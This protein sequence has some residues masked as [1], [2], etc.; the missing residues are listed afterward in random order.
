MGAI[1]NVGFEAI[2]NIVNERERNGKFKSL[3]D[4]IDRVDAKDVNK[5]QLEG[6]VKAGVFDEF[7]N[8]RGQ[9]FNSIPK[10][11][12]QIKNVNEDKLNNQTS[13]F[14]SN[15]TKSDFDYLSF[16]EWSKKELLNEEFKSLGFFISDHPLND[17]KEIFNHLKIVSYKN[18][19]NSSDSEALVAGTIMS[20]Q[21]KKSAKGTP[22]AIVKFSDNGGEFEL[23]L[24]A[25]IL[26]NNRDKIRES[27]SFV[28]TLHKDKLSNDVNQ[29]RINLKKILSLEDMIDKP[30]SKVTIEL[31]EH[32]DLEEI[33]RILNNQGQTQVILVF[34][35]KNKKIT[36]NLKNSRKFDFNQLKTMENKEYVKKITV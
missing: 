26:I 32:H 33:K 23:F 28:L 30:Y 8:N 2:S 4:F 20:I 25:E 15:S 9:I 21:E 14:E 29:R 3:V 6:L 19:I 7:N 31:N 27:E 22:F 11:I 36:Y 24:F 34:H 5:L 18:F 16:K 1:K 10:I 17:Y 13:L 35:E 12:Q